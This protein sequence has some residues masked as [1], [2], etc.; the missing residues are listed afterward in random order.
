MDFRRVNHS[1]SIG[2]KVC[3]VLVLAMGLAA[4]ADAPTS[5]LE[6]PSRVSGSI[7]IETPSGPNCCVGVG[8]SDARSEYPRLGA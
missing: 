7:A 5:P 8:V 3:F 1:S 4:C 6:P 2:K